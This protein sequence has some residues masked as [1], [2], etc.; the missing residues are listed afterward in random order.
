MKPRRRMSFLGPYRGPM[1]DYR[2]YRPRIRPRPIRAPE[3]L[4]IPDFNFG[5]EPRQQP[6]TQ[7]K[8]TPVNTRTK[9]P[10]LV[11]TR[12]RRRGRPPKTVTAP[13]QPDYKS[14]IRVSPRA[15]GSTYSKFSMRNTCSYYDAIK[16]RL[17]PRQQHVVNTG[18]K[19]AGGS[20]LQTYTAR[21]VMTQS[22]IG[23]YFSDISQ[24]NA[25]SELYLNGVVSET[26]FSN[27]TNSNTF[28]KLY[29]IISRRPTTNGPALGMV[30]G[31]SDEGLSGSTP[32]PNQQYS[33]GLTPFDSNSFCREWKVIGKPRIIEL[34]EGRTHI[35]TSSFM[36]NKKISLREN[37]DASYNIPQY[38]CG[39][40][41]LVTGAPAENSA[42]PTDITTAPTDLAVVYTE[43]HYF[44]YLIPNTETAVRTGTLTQGAT[45]K[46]EDAASGNFV[47]EVQN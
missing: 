1:S 23:T 25:T 44:R 47:P 22:D 4:T 31:L 35:H 26:M 34:A 10:T 3:D 8:L 9:Y 13:R 30:Q 5:F 37:S 39:I 28:I 7:P 24:T 2:T 16:K 29:H 19:V 45:V 20:G 43:K 32:Q 12:G 18:L 6:Q 14:P 15:A 11:G 42:T 21:I 27:L 17:A 38:S 41:Y 33:I 40:L 36:I 46:V